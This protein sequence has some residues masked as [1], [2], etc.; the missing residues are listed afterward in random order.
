[1]ALFF[2]PPERPEPHGRRIVS[3]G[4]A[5]WIAVAGSIQL[6]TVF[7]RPPAPVLSIWAPLARLYIVN[8]Y[9]LFAIMTTTRLEI[10][11]QGSNDGETWLDYE[12]PYKPGD[13]KR[14]PPLVAPHQPRL[15]WQMWF[16]AL[17]EHRQNPWF[18]NFLVRLLEGSP[19]AL[20]LVEKNP[21]PTSP[22]RYIRAVLYDYRFTDFE[23]RLAEGAWWRREYTGLYYPVA[24]LPAL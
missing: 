1:V 14:R 8:S 17:G 7:A 3:L 6:A 19:E 22:P 21:F 16:A 23:V 15:D 12:F 24:S 2:D 9:G 10:I 4:A 11:V 13:P 20:S 5:A 18:T